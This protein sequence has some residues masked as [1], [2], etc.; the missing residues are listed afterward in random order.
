MAPAVAGERPATGNPTATARN[1]VGA[2]DTMSGGP[3]RGH[4]AAHAKGVLVEGSFEPHPDAG[5]L[6][7]ATHMSHGPVPVIVRFSNFSGVPTVPDGDA[8]ATPNGMAIKFL[9]PDGGSTDI[10]AH[11]FDG[12]PASTP[13]EFLAFLEAIGSADAARLDRHLAAHPAAR[14]FVETPKP[15]PA[16]Y[17]RQRF[18][19]VNAFRFTN[20]A[21]TTRFGR[22][23]IEPE[24]GTRFLS[25]EAA[26]QMAPDFLA[27]DLRDRLA[28]APVRF[29][30]AVQLAAE[31]D[32]LDDAAMS[33][34]EGREVRELGTLVLRTAAHPERGQGLLFTPLNL[35]DGILP[36]DDPMLVSRT[37]AYRMSHDRRSPR[38]A[39][40]AAAN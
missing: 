27:T 11:S 1:I 12:F 3:H 30:L 10:V 29:R 14:R 4:P 17:A 22:Y 15:T 39:E 33:W 26:A 37:R 21:G 8:S 32:A 16:S 7:R 40:G 20:A 28:G 25:A 31:G 36:S 34:P 35:V 13:Q 23:R 19:G 18:Y 5:A 24:A 38:H 9:L 2:L 6:T